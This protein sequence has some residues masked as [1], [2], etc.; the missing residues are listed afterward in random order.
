VLNNTIDDRC[1]SIYGRDNRLLRVVEVGVDGA[2]GVFDG[3]DILHVFV[4]RTSLQMRFE[5]ADREIFA[6]LRG[7]LS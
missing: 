4:E 5:Q 7:A 3:I 6:C 1:C 2:R